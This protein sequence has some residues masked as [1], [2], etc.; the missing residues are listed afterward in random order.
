MWKTLPPLEV[1]AAAGKKTRKPL[2][3][4]SEETDEFLAAQHIPTEGAFCY[5]AITGELLDSTLQ[6]LD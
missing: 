3:P 4:S 5:V 6:Q 2:H 1:L